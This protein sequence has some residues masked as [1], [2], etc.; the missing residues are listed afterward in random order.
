MNGLPLS[1]TARENNSKFIMVTVNRSNQKKTVLKIKIKEIE[2]S[3]S[4]ILNKKIG[5]SQI[6]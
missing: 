2:I 4:F 6:F 1:L 5:I 3:L